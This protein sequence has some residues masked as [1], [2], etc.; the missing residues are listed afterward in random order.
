MDVDDTAEGRRVFGVP[1]SEVLALTGGPGTD[2]QEV[3]ILCGLEE[4]NYDQG[5]NP[6]NGFVQKRKT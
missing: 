5:K 1:R 4:V 6:L 3:V 2:V